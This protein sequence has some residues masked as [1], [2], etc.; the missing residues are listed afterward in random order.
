[1]CLLTVMMYCED[2]PELWMP[3]DFT[4]L[5]YIINTVTIDRGY[6]KF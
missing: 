3:T 4:D 5:L 2:K 6:R 1:M